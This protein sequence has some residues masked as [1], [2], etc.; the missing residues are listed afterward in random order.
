MSNL[1]SE[2]FA[3]QQINEK[4]NAKVSSNPSNVQTIYEVH[5]TLNNNSANHDKDFSND[6][7]TTKP[8]EKIFRT[9]DQ[10][11][12]ENQYENTRDLKSQH[13][14]PS[15]SENEYEL[16]S[17]F[18]SDISI[19]KQDNSKD[20]FEAE[21]QKC[22]HNAITCHKYYSYDPKILIEYGNDLSKYIPGFYRL[23]D[24]CKD[25]GLQGLDK[26]IIYEESLKNLCNDIDPLCFKSISEISYAKLNLVS[27]Y[28][29]GCYGNHTLI[30][31]LLLKK[32]IINE[33]LYNLL[34]TSHSSIF[35]D[36]INKPSLRP[37]IYLLILNSDLGLII[38]WPEV[39]CYEENGSS[40]RKKNMVNLHRY[41]TKLTD[42][43]ICFMSDKDLE[44]FD[45]NFDNSD[46]S[47]NEDDENCYNF[48]VTKSQEGRDDFKIYPGFKVN[49]SCIN[50]I[51]N[52]VQY[53][54][55]LYPIVIESTTNQ[56]FVTRKLLKEISKLELITNVTADTFPGYLKNKLQDHCIHFNRNTMNMRALE[57]FVKYG[58]EM[59]DELLSSYH[60][61]L[62]DAKLQNDMKK[63]RE[64]NEMNDD[65]KIIKVMALQKLKESYSYFEQSIEQKDP[66]EIHLLQKDISNNDLKRIQKK[67]PK[68]EYKIV[69]RIQINTYRWKNMKKRYYLT[70]KIIKDML[71]DVNDNDEITESAIE[72]FD[73]MFKDE[74]MD[75]HKLIDKYIQQNSLLSNLFKNFQN[76]YI[77]EIAQKSI[78]MTRYNDIN[79]IQELLEIQLFEGYSDANENIIAAF[80]EEYKIW[81]ESTYSENINGILPQ[82]VFDTEL[83]NKI[84]QDYKKEKH[85]IEED[86]FAR[87]CN[88]IEKKYEDRPMR[89]TIIN[90]TEDYLSHSFQIYTEV[91]IV[92]PNQLQITIHETSLEQPDSFHIYDDEFYIS[93]PILHSH[94]STTFPLDPTTY[95]FRKISQF[96]RKFL[97][98]LWNKERSRI[99]IFFNTAYRLAQCFK[100]SNL[101]KPFKVLNTSEKVLVAINEP[102]E[103]IAL[104][105]S[106]KVLLYVF[107]LNDNRSTLYGH[108][109][110]IHLLQWYN[111]KVPFVK[112][113]LFFKGTEE[114]CFVE[115]SGR[116]RIFNLINLQFKPAVCNFP[117]NTVNVLS[118]PDGSCIVAFVKNKIE[119]NKPIEK[120]EET[121][122][123]ISTDSHNEQNDD[124]NINETCRAHVCFYTRFDSISKVI[125]LPANIQSL[126]FLQFTC[127]NKMQTHLMSFDLKNGCFN[128]VIV[129]IIL[130]KNQYRFQEH[131]QKKSHGHVGHVKF[132]DSTNI[133]PKTKLNNLIDVYKLMFEKYPID[134]CI[135][136]EQNHS[137]SLKIALDTDDDE[138]EKYG[139]KFEG[140]ISEMFEDLKR[141]TKKPATILKEFSTSVI[142]FQKL[143]IE[144]VKFQEKYPSKYKLGEWI[145][146]LC[147]LIPIQIAVVRNGL[148]QPLRDELFLNE[149]DQIEFNE[150]Y[151]HHVDRIAKNISFGWY[152]GIFKHFGDKKVKVVSNMGERSCGKSYMLNHLV[153]TTFDGSTMCCTEGVWMSLVNTNEYIYVALDFEGL[154]SL[155]RTSQEDLLLVLFNTLTSNLILFKNQFTINRDMS[156]M[157]QRFQDG[158]TLFDS[159]SKLFQAELCIIIKDVPRAIR[160]EIVRL[161]FNQFITEE[162]EV[163]FITKMFKGGLNII[164]WPMFNEDSWYKMLATIKKILDK[165]EAKYENAR[166]FLQASKIIMAKLKICDLSS[167][168]EN[169]IHNCVTILKRL[170]PTAISHGLEQKDFIIEHLMNHD[171]GKQIEDPIVKI[172]DILLQDS[173]SSEIF[174]DSSDCPLNM[175]GGYP[176]QLYLE[177]EKDYWIQVGERSIMADSNISL[178]NEYEYFAQLSG[179]L[180]CYFE[181]HIQLRKKSSDD[182]KWFTKLNKFFKYIINRRISRVQDWYAQN[183]AKFPQDNSD[184]INGKY[185]M[186]HEITKLKL[187]WT[188]CG[189]TCSK[190][191]LK[192]VKNRNHSEDHDC[193]TQNLIFES[194]FLA[195][196][197]NFLAKMKNQFHNKWK[198][199]F[200]QVKLF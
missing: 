45:W 139:E 142:T 119:V 91:E 81:R 153:G 19:T 104:Y 2:S 151:G 54:I 118:S 39:G 82:F 129:K 79:F 18:W 168:D 14:I 92:R 34:I 88:E 32:N 9:S 165:Q 10:D 53:D 52:R 103:L 169:L 97:L 50:E 49:L 181:E 149:Y 99:E 59:D 93:I 130:E 69:E 72:T 68:I 132:I 13:D 87:I 194:K 25:E 55:P 75:P 157:F 78:Q 48:K 170:L 123:I 200:V 38:H 136:P 171:T 71:K 62:A 124:D 164:P 138:I 111:N 98:I 167:L 176:T 174:T 126:E 20:K 115:D 117:P 152:E 73:N 121:D 184:I 148:F 128:S 95:E 145:I 197:G 51:N 8:S 191:D 190:C 89:L 4:T 159:D 192:C 35:M 179:D 195:K 144:N 114:L 70:Y 108:Y 187:L 80:F 85:K 198:T 47:S 7:S 11:Q 41:L 107:S 96:D 178:C 76:K 160:E 183:T 120:S 158:A 21:S 105:D 58:L 17:D 116:A 83:N 37:G 109:T 61:A 150:G 155:E 147:C 172:S 44:S 101:I 156:I 1:N 57:I 122:S 134:S 131:M 173:E 196:I 66:T 40:Q 161:R 163:N 188:L 6:K 60:G 90:V 189:L 162:E 64:K 42:Y 22:I 12:Y 77:N 180:R 146:Q 106:E 135:D 5:S 84:D 3:Q 86:E 166:T 26:I 46:T 141:S 193:L 65:I 127:I 175:P 15:D 24:L 199:D 31:K 112:Y 33:Q 28:L 29:I 23:L 67:Y 94:N 154:K 177:Q 63:N 133:E 102:K 110:N 182:S 143:N 125:D 56:S 140:Y 30:A 100:T 137:L 74:E 16:I 185:A 27:F 113:F 43:Q 36:Y 186:K